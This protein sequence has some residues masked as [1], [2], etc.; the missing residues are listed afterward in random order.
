MTTLNKHSTDY[1]TVV[2]QLRAMADQVERHGKF[3]EARGYSAPLSVESFLVALNDQPVL[4]VDK[5]LLV[6]KDGMPAGVA[7]KA[8]VCILG[9]GAM[10]GEKL[11]EVL[12]AEQKD[13]WCA[14][15]VA[16]SLKDE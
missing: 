16:G 2:A 4:E 7:A 10:S 9:V 12:A 14:P 8:L 3:R 6:N 15:V 13:A 1:K 5:G 11:A